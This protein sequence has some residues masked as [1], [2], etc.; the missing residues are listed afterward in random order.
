MKETITLKLTKPARKQG[1]DRY[2]DDKY[3]I[4]F[5]VPQ[6]LSRDKGEPAKSVELTIETD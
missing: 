1:G 4:V 3:G 2:E 5:Y 6:T